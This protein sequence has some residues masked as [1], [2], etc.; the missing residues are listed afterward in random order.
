V[1]GPVDIN[2]NLI[3]TTTGGATSS[4]LFSTGGASFLSSTLM[5]V[6][7]NS[8]EITGLTLATIAAFGGETHEL[9]I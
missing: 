1:G 5:L 8:L 7:A 2:G 3:A 6:G 4:Q 9:V